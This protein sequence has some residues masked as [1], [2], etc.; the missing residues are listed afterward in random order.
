MIFWPLIYL[1]QHK[2]PTV[3]TIEA[4]RIFEKEE[5]STLYHIKSLHYTHRYWSSILIIVI[6]ERENPLQNALSLSEIEKTFML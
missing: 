1:K 6:F 4:Q 2:N 3:A 5:I